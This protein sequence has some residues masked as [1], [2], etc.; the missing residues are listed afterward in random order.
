MPSELAKKRKEAKAKRKAKLLAEKGR[1]TT[2]SKEKAEAEEA[3]KAEAA[4]PLDGAHLR[5]T[6]RNTTGVL[7][8]HPQSSDV[9]FINFSLAYHGQIMFEDTTLEFTHGKRYGLIGPNGAGKSTLLKA[10][11]EQ[12]IAFPEHIDIFYLEKEADPTDKTALEAV[13]EVEGETKRLEAEAE[14]LVEEDPE[15][16]RLQQLYERLDELDVSA[17]ETRA[18]KLLHG[19][20]FDKEMQ[21][22]KCK[23]FSGGWRMRIALARAL[24]VKPSLL[25]LDEPTNHLDLEACVWLEYE[26]AKYDQCLVLISHSQDFLN[27]VCTDIMHLHEKK[28]KVYSGNYERFIT[29]RKELEENQMKKYAWEQEKIADM[30]DYIARV[31]HGSAKLAR[32]AQS[33]E[34]VLKKMVD[35]GLTKKVTHDH[36]VNFKFPDCGKLP[37]PVLMVENVSFKYPGTEHFLY[38]DLEFGLDLDTRLA[39]LGPNGAGKSTLLNLILGELQPTEGM[40]RR[41]GH[42]R[43]ARYNQHLEEQLDFELTPIEFMQKEFPDRFVEV[44]AARRAIGPFGVTGK[45][46]TMPIKNMSDGQRSRIVFAW[47]AQSAPHM[48]VLDEPTNHLDMEMIDSLANAIKSFEG[49]VVLVSH[50]FRL[51][52]QVADQIWIAEK[53]TVTRWEGPIKSYKEHILASIDE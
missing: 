51:I 43:I 50:D 45:M 27:G 6:H 23:D 48:L 40:I 16:D 44:E 14:K 17:I 35:A 8:S 12:D 37:I 9:K 11:A 53:Q 47:L 38:K 3:R 4:K 19:L 2:H 28:L 26:L 13:M 22:K 29:T 5:E 33:K 30:K 46:Q 42:L 21:A 25:L 32:Q 34:K 52:D 31:G 49:G 24:L 1:G 36:A 39:I 7:A 15:S 20:G 10:L 18:A 41:N